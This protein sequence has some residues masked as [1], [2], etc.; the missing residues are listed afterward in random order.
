MKYS[1][2]FVFTMF[3]AVFNV[4]ASSYTTDTNLFE[5]SY[6]N[7]LID[8]AQSNIDNFYTKD[9]VIFQ[10][11]YNYYIIFFIKFQ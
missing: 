8:M 2:I 9:F 11:G 6:S 7:N 5:N 10:N 3:L 1:L 4:S